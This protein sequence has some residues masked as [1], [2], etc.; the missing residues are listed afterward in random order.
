MFRKI[1]NSLTPMEKFSLKLFFYFMMV[2]FVVVTFTLGFKLLSY[3]DDIHNLMGF[4]L[5]VLGWVMGVTL[6]VKLAK[7]FLRDKSKNK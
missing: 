4:I 7:A 2:F 1:F 3:A 5:I 6:G